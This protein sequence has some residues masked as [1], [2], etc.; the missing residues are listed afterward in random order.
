MDSP[1][2]RD[3]ITVLAIGLLVLLTPVL[4]VVL[5]LEIL[6]LSG[7]IVLS[8]VTPL[9]FFELYLVD[10][11]LLIGFGYGVYRL[12]LWLVEH[13]LPASLDALEAASDEEIVTDDAEGIENSSDNR[14]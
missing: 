8:Q 9:E 13:R 11:A 2:L 14:Q 7:D 10:L 4:F 1:D 12:T 6:I 3:R 5:S